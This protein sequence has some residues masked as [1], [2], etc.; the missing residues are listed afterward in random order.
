MVNRKKIFPF[1]IVFI[2]VAFGVLYNFLLHRS[3]WPDPEYVI[4][5]YGYFIDDVIN[6]S[7]TI[8]NRLSNIIALLAYKIDGF[9][10]R[11]IRI[12]ASLLYGIVLMGAVIASLYAYDEAE[13]INKNFY[14]V[15]L[16]V[17]LLILIN[18]IYYLIHLLFFSRN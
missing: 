7:Y 17:F 9:G 12:E 8:G 1:F 10:I 4:R 13:Y 15:S 6:H 18:L 5:Q 2:I 14:L 16:L 11:S 3:F